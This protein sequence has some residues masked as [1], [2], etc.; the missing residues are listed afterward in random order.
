MEEQKKEQL[1]RFHMQNLD[2]V[3]NQEL[4]VDILFITT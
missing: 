1:E 2:M 3:D 4:L